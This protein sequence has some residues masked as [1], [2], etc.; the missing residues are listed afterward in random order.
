[1][2]KPKN[3]VQPLE[4]GLCKVNRMELYWQLVM[5]FTHVDISVVG[6]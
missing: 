1:M 2:R 6:M 5:K 4:I 3:T